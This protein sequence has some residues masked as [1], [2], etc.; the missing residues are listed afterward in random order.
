MDAAIRYDTTRYRCPHCRRSYAHQK[1]ADKHIVRCFRNPAVRSCKTCRFYS[2]D[3]DGFG[4]GAGV[5]VSGAFCPVCGSGWV[6]PDGPVCEHVDA[7]SVYNLR[8]Q[9]DLWEAGG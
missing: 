3:F 4:C 7:K 5:D 2:L 6:Q 8:V 9:C 1:T